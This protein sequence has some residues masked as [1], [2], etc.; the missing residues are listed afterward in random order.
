LVGKN[1]ILLKQKTCGGE[2]TENNQPGGDEH[3]DEGRFDPATDPRQWS[4]AVNES[5]CFELA[6]SK[7]KRL[8]KIIN[9]GQGIM[10]IVCIFEDYPE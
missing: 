9:T 8:V 7:G 5:A 3:S 6:R 2:L 4:A 10:P 1:R